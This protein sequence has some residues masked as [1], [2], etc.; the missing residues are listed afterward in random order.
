MHTQTIPD[1]DYK[2]ALKETDPSIRNPPAA[3]TP[4]EAA[5]LEAVKALFSDYSRE[6]LEANI[7][8]V[9]ADEVYFRD[10]FKQFRTSSEIEEYMLAGLEP[11]SDA[12]FVFN[13]VART[14]SEFYLDW[15][16]RLDFKSTPDGT[17]EESIGVTH[18]RFNSE[19]KVI[20][21]QDYWDPTD[22]VYRRIP[23]AKQLIAYVKKK[24]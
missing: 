1:A 5:M 19:G 6:N 7:K 9:Y 8:K 15:T 17:W 21:H 4:E 22:I 14:G 16:M 18:M 23:I 13:R 12:E 24:L 10:A 2:T 3:G 11:L 20:F